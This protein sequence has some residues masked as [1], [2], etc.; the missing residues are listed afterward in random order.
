[1][2]FTCKPHYS[3]ALGMAKAGPIPMISGG[4]PAHAKLSILP[5]I[6]RPSF[7]ATDLLAKRITD[8]PSVTWLEFPAVVVPPFL[9]AGFN[10][11]RPS[12]VVSGLTPSSLSTNIFFE[13][14]SLSLIVVS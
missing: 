2:S 14:P 8:A 13:F 1:M 12:K 5:L 6:G 11:P 3:N 10:L 9:K 7:N 4:T